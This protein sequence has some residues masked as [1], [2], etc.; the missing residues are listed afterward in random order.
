MSGDLRVSLCEVVKSPL[1][2]A[3][4][5]GQKVYD[6]IVGALKEGRPVTLSCLHVTSLTPAFLHAAVGQL[7]GSFSED[8]IQSLIRVEGM[9]VED[10]DLVKR[11]MESA[12]QYYEDPESFQHA[13][14]EVLGEEDD[15]AE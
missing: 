1:C 7:Y 15:D 8:Q 14:G 13:V 11:V 6:Q 3:S 2:V 4:D 10:R 12:K 9:Q 5:D